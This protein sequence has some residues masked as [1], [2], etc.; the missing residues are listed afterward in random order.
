MEKPTLIAGNWKM[1][2]GPSATKKFLAELENGV[3]RNPSLKQALRE[4]MVELA[5]FPPFTSLCGAVEGRSFLPWLK[6]GGQNVHW[7]LEGAYTGEV[8]PLMLK[9]TGCDYVLI[10]HSERRQLFG[11]SDDLIREKTRSSVSSGLSVILC[12]G[13]TLDER[14]S[15]VTFDV[16]ERQLLRALVGLSPEETGNDVCVAYE[17]VWAIGTGR[18]AQNHEAQE[19]CQAIR[20]L[21]AERFGDEAASELRIL[22]GGS[23][24]PDNA[25]GLLNEPDINGALVGGASLKAETF[26]QILSAT[27]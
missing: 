16:I 13:E 8:S 27:L 17:P 25:A 21:V 20:R 1:N 24:K 2:H 12:V 19:A 3:S 22:Y 10:G 4:G 26:L 7:A 9:E 14:E 6:V 5:L 23:V 15:G 11:E 18:T